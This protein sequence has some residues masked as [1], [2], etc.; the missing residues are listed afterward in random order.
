M[1]IVVAVFCL[2]LCTHSLSFEAKEYNLKYDENRDPFADFDRAKGDAAVENKLIFILLGGEWCGWCLKL[3]KFMKTNA[4]VNGLLRDR[5]VF[6]KVNVSE[7]NYNEAFLATLP[8]A[9]GYPF[10]VVADSEGK[11]L[12]GQST[13]AL[14]DGM[15]YSVPAF[16]QFVGRWQKR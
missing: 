14:Q 15:E 2:L 10:M 13:A 4:E 1:K 8:A 5:F 16:R 11:V 9:D 7:E 12:V 6:L 3:E